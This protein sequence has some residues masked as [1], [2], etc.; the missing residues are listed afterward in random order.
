MIDYLFICFSLSEGS[1]TGQTIAGQS[2]VAGTSPNQLSSPTSVTFD[3]YENMYVMDSGNERIQRWSSG[4]LSGT[5]LVATT[6]LF[7][8]RGLA[9][10]P[11]GNLAVADCSNHRVVSFTVTCRKFFVRSV[12][13]RKYP[14]KE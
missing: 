8:P 9:I 4:S 11:L 5:T 13:C 3:Q 6:A 2:G 10:D 12:L 14:A 1:S 7:N